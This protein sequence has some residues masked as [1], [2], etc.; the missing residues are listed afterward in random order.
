MLLRTKK[1]YQAFVILTNAQFNSVN[2]QECYVLTYCPACKKLYRMFINRSRN[3]ERF[4]S[5]FLEGKYSRND[6]K[7]N[8]LC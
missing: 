2:R 4:L 1:L 8:A 7:Q 6:V 3:N 5:F